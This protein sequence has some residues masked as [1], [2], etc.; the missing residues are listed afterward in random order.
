MAEEEEE[1]GSDM[2]EVEM[3]DGQ[4]VR[5]K[6][7]KAGEDIASRVRND[8]RF[9]KLNKKHQKHFKAF[10]NRTYMDAL[11]DKDAD[12]SKIKDI[13]DFK[14]AERGARWALI[15]DDNGKIIKLGNRVYREIGTGRLYKRK[16]RTNSEDESFIVKEIIHKEALDT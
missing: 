8:D 2:E 15:P 14:K 5:Q 12:E 7:E 10:L 16:S 11:P 13:V 6:S 9:M 1:I 4:V 3:A